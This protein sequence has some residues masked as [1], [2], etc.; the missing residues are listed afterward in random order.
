M[1]NEVVVG[2]HSKFTKEK[3]NQITNGPPI[4]TPKE[5]I[6]KQILP[7]DCRSL[8]VVDFVGGGGQAKINRATWRGV[9]VAIKEF[10]LDMEEMEKER[11]ALTSQRSSDYR[12]NFIIKILG[13]CKNQN[14]PAL[15]LEWAPYKSLFKLVTP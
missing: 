10:L 4:P 6:G 9:H 15:I 2:E 14:H 5:E 11:I 7:V 8:P 1:E 12:A 13:Y 3:F